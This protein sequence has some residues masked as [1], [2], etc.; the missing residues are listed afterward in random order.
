[1]VGV[2]D[3][4][5]QSSF[6]DRD[7]GS[8]NSNGSGNSYGSGNSNGGESWG[9][10]VSGVCTE[11]ENLTL[12]T[13]TGSFGQSEGFSVSNS[14]SSF[15]F[16]NLSGVLNGFQS[17]DWNNSGFSSSVSS[18]MG[19][20]SSSNF[21]SFLDGF[22][23]SQISNGSFRQGIGN[24]TETQRVGYV[25]DADFFAFGVD[26]SVATDLV[27]ECVLVV[28]SGL[29]GVGITV[30]GLTK[31]ILG[32]VL[33]AGV[34]VV[35]G[36]VVGVGGYGSNWGSDGGGVSGGVSGTGGQGSSVTVAVWRAV[37]AGVVE[38]VAV[39]RIL[40]LGNNCQHQKGSDRVFHDY[41]LK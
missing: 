2:E 29:T 18:F 7:S 32:V 3:S 16:S 41:S 25:A 20:T 14:V 19:Q 40:G 4:F 11:S 27:A 5:G 36:V 8:G 21:G 9:E 10:S 28:G 15:S 6:T 12:L 33:A 1:M 31:F 17:A 37:E 26:V 24:D 23:H 39:V 13:V 34:G 22:G 35:T 38:S 30:T